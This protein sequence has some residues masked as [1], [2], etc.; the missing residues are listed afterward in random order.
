MEYKIEN[1]NGVKA[2]VVN[3]DEPGVVVA[4]APNGSGK[5][6]AIEALKAACGDPQ[7][8]AE[9]TDGVSKG[10]VL[11][12]DGVTFTVGHRR[13][14]NGEPAVRLVST[15]AIGKLIDPQIKDDTLAARARVRALMSLLPLPADDEARLEL[16]KNDEEL[17]RWIAS[18]PATDAMELGEAVRK[19]ANELANELEKQ[20][21]QAQGEAAA[22]VKQIEELGPLDY[23]AGEVTKARALAERAV[24]EAEVMGHTARARQRHE[25][26]KQRIAAVIGER[27]CSKLASEQV[28]GLAE[29]IREAEM[30]VA[31]LRSRYQEAVRERVRLDEEA[32]RWDEQAAI[33]KQ[34]VEGP[35]LEDAAK[36]AT[37][38]EQLKA[39]AVR[40]EILAQAMSYKRSADLASSTAERC[41]NRAAVLRAIAKGTADAMGRL[42]ERRGLPGLAMVDGRLCVRAGDKL[43]DFDTRLS[44]GERVRVALGIA[45]AGIDRGSVEHRSAGNRLPLLPLEPEFW[46]ALDGKHRAEVAQIARERGV[47]LVTEEPAEGELR[48]ERVA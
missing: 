3:L 5:S 23:E 4:K 12:P 26:E 2:L 21:Q 41:G 28:A 7:A 1:V 34:V 35:S 13:K 30:K 11:C 20:S 45:L 29:E 8:K 31:G 38:A 40:A 39:R 16:T 24:R 19:R 43:K 9:P 27:P 33:V 44:F 37:E 42:L 17:Q 10:Q 22:M 14:L 25:E 36:A 32:R 18:E 46:L 15:G 47:C 6:S 48:F